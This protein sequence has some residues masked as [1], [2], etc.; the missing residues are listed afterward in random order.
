MGEGSLPIVLDPE[1]RRCRTIGIAGYAVNQTGR[2]G[3]V[4]PC[5]LIAGAAY[6]M[7]D[8]GQDIWSA[9]AR[10]RVSRASIFNYCRSCRP[11]WRDGKLVRFAPSLCRRCCIAKYVGVGGP[12]RH[13]LDEPRRSHRL[14]APYWPRLRTPNQQCC[15]NR[16]QARPQCRIRAVSRPLLAACHQISQSHVRGTS[17]PGRWIGILHRD[18]SWPLF[19]YQRRSRRQV[20]K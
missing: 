15:S 20:I 6:A 3:Y 19:L 17:R 5:G 18:R 7:P 4:A 1:F 14:Q 13:N 16:L 10:L 12:V 9:M 2:I 11:E 8:H